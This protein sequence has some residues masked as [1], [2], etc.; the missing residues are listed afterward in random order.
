[1]IADRKNADFCEKKV[2][3]SKLPMT[4]ASVLLGISLCGEF[5]AVNEKSFVCAF[6]DDTGFVKGFHGK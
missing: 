6:A 5:F 3:R 4:F 2:I 1:M